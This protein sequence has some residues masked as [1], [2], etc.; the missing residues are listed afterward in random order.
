MCVAAWE[1]N[2][3]TCK[4]L[5][6]AS[7]CVVDAQRSWFFHVKGIL[8][9]LWE[10]FIQL[11]NDTIK[12][13]F[14]FFFEAYWP[15][16]FVA[17]CVRVCVHRWEVLI[18][19]GLLDGHKLSAELENFIL[20]LRERTEGR[21]RKIHCWGPGWPAKSNEEKIALCRLCVRGPGLGPRQSPGYLIYIL[22]AASCFLQCW[23]SLRSQHRRQWVD[24]GPA[25]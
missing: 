3:V 8:W 19:L 18:D 12:K 17:S 13:R 21:G 4:T 22:L 5:S 23:Q 11:A 6:I 1:L 20:P 2:E 15:P 14:Y 7:W 10:G 9:G 24:P 25:Q 16:I